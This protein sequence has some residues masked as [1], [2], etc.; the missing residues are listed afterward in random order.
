MGGDGG[1]QIIVNALVLHTKILFEQENY[2]EK[3]TKKS[4]SFIQNSLVAKKEGEFH[5]EIISYSFKEIKKEG[6]FHTEIIS[7]SFKE[8]IIGA[9][10]REKS[11]KMIGE[12]SF[13]FLLFYLKPL[14]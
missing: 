6:E 2:P 10:L 8:I 12:V 1:G 13:E 11:C 5:T 3:V 7:Y 9:E 4:G 14:R